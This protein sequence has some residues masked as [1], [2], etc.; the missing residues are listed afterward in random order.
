MARGIWIDFDGDS[1][2]ALVNAFG[3]T[4]SQF[5]A[6]MRSTYGK[7]GRW[8]RSRGTRE[9]SA[10]LKIKQKILRGRI[11][12]FGLQGGIGDHG[13][14][15]GAKVWFGLRPISLTRLNARQVAGGVRADGGRFVEGAFIA[16]IDGHRQVMKRVGKSRLPIETVYADIDEPALVYVEDNLI[17][18]AEFDQQFFKY[19]EHE[20]KWRTQILK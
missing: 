5:E 19:L 15:A 13:R 8:L 18:T 2:N 7:M 11:K 20:L 16:N 3:A 14:A 9:L 12:A 17:G 4:E 6:A 1:I 10:L